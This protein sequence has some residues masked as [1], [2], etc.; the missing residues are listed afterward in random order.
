MKQDTM[1]FVKNIR[2]IYL[3]LDKNYTP[4][5]KMDALDNGE[6][7]LENMFRPDLVNE[8]ISY[9]KILSELLNDPD[10]LDDMNL[11]DSFDHKISDKQ[12]LY[13][14]NRI[15]EEMVGAITRKKSGKKSVYTLALGIGDGDTALCYA[16]NLK[17]KKGDRLTALDLRPSRLSKA[18]KKIR[19]LNTLVFDLNKLS[20]GERLPIEDKSVD[21]VE[22]TMVA[23][24]IEHF[25]DLIAEIYRVLKKGGC[26]FYLDLIDKTRTE[27]DMTFFKDHQYPP[28]HG[29]E[30]FRDHETVK[31]IVRK[32]LYIYQY[33]RVGPG[34]LFLAGIKE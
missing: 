14:T 24:H 9:S 1:Q 11:G 8:Y 12:K 2:N 7:D 21:I 29:V 22:C 20:T 15:I 13:G 25:Q 6:V 19:E 27:E 34:I 26:F 32:Y 18:K 10:F 33:N 30:F 16:Q 31:A 5:L 17:P 4:Y 23:H 3:Y 28:F